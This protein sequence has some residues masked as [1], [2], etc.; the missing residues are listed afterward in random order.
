MIKDFIPY[1]QA[2]ELKELGFNEECMAIYFVPTK[3]FILGKKVN[4][5]IRGDSKRDTEN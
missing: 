1:E 3:E 5:S 4:G 2:L